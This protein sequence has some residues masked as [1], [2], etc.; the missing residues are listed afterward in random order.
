MKLDEFAKR[1]GLSKRTIHFDIDKKLLKPTKCENNYY[2]FSPDD[3]E[4]LKTIILLRKA[5]MPIEYI[6]ELSQYPAWLNY[7]LS[8]TVKRLKAEI[9]NKQAQIENAL[10]LLDT[11]APHA[12]PADLDIS[13]IEKMT[14]E[15]KK[16]SISDLYDVNDDFMVAT[17]LLVQYIDSEKNFYKRYIWNKISIE[18][19][20]YLGNMMD[21]LL[22]VI[23]T[24]DIDLMTEDVTCMTLYWRDLVENEKHGLCVE[25]LV[26]ALQ[27]LSD[28]EELLQKWTVLYKPFIKPL[29]SFYR[30]KADEMINAYNPN[31][32]DHLDKMRQVIK[33]RHRKICDKPTFDEMKIKLTGIFDFDTEN[34]YSDYF[35]L[36]LFDD[37]FYT[38]VDIKQIIKYI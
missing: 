20:H 3:V 27:K 5:G 14:G 11:I 21:F 34:V 28:D 25:H 16:E 26:K 12:T 23:Y 4:K 10:L 8:K 32:Q 13:L 18:L 36:Y 9:E 22:D 6:N 24:R 33:N 7:Y 29:I 19:R 38:K 1:T 30:E 2:D 35:I 37:S 15:P 31:Y 17:F